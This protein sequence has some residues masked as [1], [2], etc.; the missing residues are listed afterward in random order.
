M[1]SKASH[2]NARLYALTKYRAKHG[3]RHESHADRDYIERHICRL[4]LTLKAVRQYSIAL[5]WWYSVLFRIVFK[6]IKEA[7]LS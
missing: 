1:I 5:Y 7:K 2:C 3:S 4:K 6:Y